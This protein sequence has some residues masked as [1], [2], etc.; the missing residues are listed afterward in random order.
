MASVVDDIGGEPVVRALVERFYDIIET[1]P[2]GARILDLHFQGHGLSH[3]RVEQ[4]EF[5]S[6]FFG[7]RRYYAERHGHM[8]LREIHAHV[9][10]H[11]QDAE[12]WLACMARALDD[13]GIHGPARE[14][15]GLAFDRAARMLVNRD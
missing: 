7:G 15:I 4:F 2:E 1:A 8:N 13:V 5:L 11:L 9:P 3:V 12:D 14:K 6:G 10:I